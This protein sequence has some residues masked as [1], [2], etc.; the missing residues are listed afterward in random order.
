MFVPAGFGQTRIWISRSS[1]SPLMR[2]TPS[3]SPSPG[4]AAF[5]RTIGLSTNDLIFNQA[6]QRLYGSVSSIAGST[7]NSVAEIDPVP[8]SITNQT[9]V[10]SEPTELGMSDDGETLYVGLDGAASIRRYNMVTHTA[11]AQFYVGNHNDNGPYAFTDIAV[12]PGNPSVIAVARRF[13]NFG[14][15]AAGGVAIFENGIQRTNTGP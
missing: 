3:P 14:G 8:G 6:T 5:I 15:S 12:V 11:G 1:L 9:F 2:S 13:R 7:G 10:G 4:A